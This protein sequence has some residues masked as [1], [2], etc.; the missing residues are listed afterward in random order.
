L[1]RVAPTQALAYQ[2]GDVLLV[3]IVAA[4]YGEIAAV[5][6]RGAPEGS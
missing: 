3:A 6:W 4:I 2:A 5:I 1:F